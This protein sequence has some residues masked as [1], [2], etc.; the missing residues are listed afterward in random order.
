[1][2]AMKLRSSEKLVLALTLFL[3]L[4]GAFFR[5]LRLEFFPTAQNFAPLMAIA[6]CGALFLP[7]WLALA[8]PLG[9]LVISDLILDAHYGWPFFSLEVWPRYIFFALAVGSGLWARRFRGAALPT[10]GVVTANSVLFYLLTNTISWIHD[11]NYAKT[12]AGLLQ[13]LTVGV[14][15]LPPTWLFLRASLV[16]DLLFAGLFLLA[17]HVAHR[18]PRPV[19]AAASAP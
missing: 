17:F 13:S 19:A 2:N 3:V 16:S 4:F 10:L 18:T 5:V 14:P 11:P 1:M 6:C 9:A 15:G 7:G 8:A 12:A